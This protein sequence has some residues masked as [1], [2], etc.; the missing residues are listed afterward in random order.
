MEH[1]LLSNGSYNPQIDPDLFLCS[2]LQMG[3]VSTFL[4]KKVLHEPASGDIIDPKFGPI[5]F[6][7]PRVYYAGSFPFVPPQYVM[8]SSGTE[9]VPLHGK[10]LCKN[11][12]RASGVQMKCAH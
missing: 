2:Q 4:Y 12:S 7:P 5:L 3:C 10:S 9:H 6:C 11:M 1:L 8:R